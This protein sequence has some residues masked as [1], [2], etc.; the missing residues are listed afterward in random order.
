MRPRNDASLKGLLKNY[1][2]SRGL[3]TQEVL[4]MYL[5]E[6]FLARLE[7]SSYSDKV[8]IKGGLLISNMIGMERRTTMDL[9][10]TVKGLEM[11]E[12]SVVAMVRDIA[13]VPANDDIEFCFE[14]IEPIRAD[15]VY[16][17]YRVHLRAKYG[18]IDAPMKLD[19]TTGDVIVP[20]EVAYSYKSLFGDENFSVMAYPVATILAEKYETVVSRG[21]SN[22]RARDFYDLYVMAKL[23]EEELDWAQ[24]SEAVMATARKRSSL[25]SMSSYRA[26][27]EEV[28][29]EPHMLKDWDAYR[30]T[31]SYAE[32][33]SFE[34]VVEAVADIGGGLDLGARR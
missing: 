5:F 16:P 33:L 2:K 25:E 30:R 7:K 8:V 10:A 3:R 14:K 27:L 28:A 26:I 1:A 24:L 31:H 13:S 21:V 4:Q 6:R 23:Y 19:V 32:G 29:S 18:K 9:D 15:D 22:T 11:E 12:E 34:E 17:N 20:C